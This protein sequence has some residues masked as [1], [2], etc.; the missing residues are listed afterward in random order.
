METIVDSTANKTKSWL[1][2]YKLYNYT[3]N[4]ELQTMNHHTQTT[5]MILIL[6]YI[7]SEI[8]GV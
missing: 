4:I 2:Y 1:N 7:S 5:A 3:R 6:L 8:L